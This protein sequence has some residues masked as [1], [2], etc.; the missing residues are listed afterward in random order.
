M[1]PPTELGIR[2]TMTRNQIVAY[3][4]AKARALRAGP[5]NKPP[6][7]SPPLGS[8]ALRTELLCLSNDPP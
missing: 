3:N 6:R 1:T 2:R 7:P 5:K 8:Q 4:V